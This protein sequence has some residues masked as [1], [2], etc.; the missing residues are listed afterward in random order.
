MAYAGGTITTINPT[1]TAPEVAHQLKDAGASLLITISAFLAVAEAAVSGTKVQKIVVM[2]QADVYASLDAMMGK[3]SGLI[4]V[5]P[6]QVLQY[7]NEKT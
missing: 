5:E 2:G 1:Y 4:T 6:V 3:S 7:D